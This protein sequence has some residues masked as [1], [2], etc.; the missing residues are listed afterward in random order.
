LLQI[1]HLKEKIMQKNW[2][3]VYTKPKLENKVAAT[4]TKRKI[5]NFLPLNRREVT[6]FRKTRIVEMALFP[7]YIFVSLSKNEFEKIKLIDGVINLIY[8]KGEPAIVKEEEIEMI[9]DFT[10][11]HQN[12]E[13]EKS[14]VNKN[15]VAK[16]ID[17]A[18][19]TLSGN[20]LTIKNTMVKV[21]LPSIGF[22]LV[23]K[24]ETKTFEMN[25][26][27]SFVEQHFLLQSEN[28]N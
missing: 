21:N 23:A 25:R 5:E 15:D 1:L 20:V 19:H 6:H 16:A 18:M 9:R 12:I 13:V 10:K 24:V 7:N 26:K 14:K 27:N 17:G 4:L 8:W 28:A 11:V 3:M 22:N 2:Y